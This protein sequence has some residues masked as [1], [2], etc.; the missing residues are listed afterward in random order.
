VFGV[1]FRPGSFRP[2]LGDPVA[3]IT[4]RSIPASDVFGPGV[5]EEAVDATADPADQAR[6]VER[7][8]RD[9]LPAPD[10]MAE[11]AAA[12]V[13][14]IATEPHLTRVDDLAAAVGMGVRRLQRLFAEHVGVGPKWVIRHYR[15]AEATT[16][17]ARREPID[18]AELAAELG[19][20]DQAHFTRDFTAMV[21]ESPTRY[22]RRYPS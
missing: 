1:A 20:A 21:G 9:R 14:Q 10:P 4:G 19:Y 6:V 5:P 18:W 15:I 12:I 22:A 8:L 13:R 2:V 16:R 7:F 3:S 11:T 17:M